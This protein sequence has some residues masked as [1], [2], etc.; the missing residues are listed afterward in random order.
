MVAACT[1]YKNTRDGWD[2]YQ[3]IL[4]QLDGS[5]AAKWTLP[6]AKAIAKAFQVEKVFLL[7]VLAQ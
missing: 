4:V 5:S 3:N 2:M 1:G 7:R 6:H